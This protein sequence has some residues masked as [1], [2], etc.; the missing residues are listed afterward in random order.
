M[1]RVCDQSK[2]FSTSFR[3]TWNSSQFRTAD[4]NKI[5]TEY[6]SLSEHTYTQP[7]Y[8]SLDFV[9]EN[10]GEPVPEETFT[11]SYLSWSS[12]IPYLLP[13]S[14]TIHG[15]LPVQLMRLAVFFHN[16][17]PSFLWCTSWSGT[18]SSVYL[19]AWHAPLHTPY[20][21]SP[22]HCLLFAVHAHTIATCCAV[23][24]RLCH[25]ILVCLS[26]NRLLGILS[27]SLMPHIHLTILPAE[28][29]PYPLTPILIINHVYQLPL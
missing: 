9:W 4:S 28:V 7:F 1:S 16:L 6:G 2:M 23:V 12:F 5:R 17:S 18:L 26:L 27:C 29:P 10:L 21:S 22:N 11:H 25:L 14:I 19:L 3:C 13:P 15:I 20:I 24:P 8:G